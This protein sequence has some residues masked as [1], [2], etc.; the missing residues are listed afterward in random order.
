MRGNKDMKICIQEKYVNAMAHNLPILR[1]ATNMTQAELAEKVGVS[2]QTIVA[3]ETKKRPIPWSL[4]LA[5]VCVFDQYDSSRKICE[6]FELFD[7]EFV[8]S[9][10]RN[11]SVKK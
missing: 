5:F 1:V 4:Y 10:S 11:S 8:K 2:R 6:S 3:L 7:S 9:I